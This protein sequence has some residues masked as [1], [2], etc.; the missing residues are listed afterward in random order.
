[1][2]VDYAH[3]SD[4]SLTLLYVLKLPS[5]AITTKPKTIQF[6]FNPHNPY[7]LRAMLVDCDY[8]GANL[9]INFNETSKSTKVTA[10]QALTCN[11]LDFASTVSAADLTHPVAITL[12]DLEAE[13]GMSGT[14]FST[15]STVWT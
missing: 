12:F 6:A 2:S 8:R 1:M 9:T 15:Q 14:T 10:A 4:T 13:A 11:A 5:S 7:E 3:S